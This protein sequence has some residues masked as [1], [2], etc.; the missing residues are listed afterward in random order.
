MDDEP[1]SDEA[2]PDWSPEDQWALAGNVRLRWERYS[3]DLP[4]DGGDRQPLGNLL[5]INGLGSP[6]V[7]WPVGFVAELNARGFDVVRFDNRDAG[8]SSATGGGYTLS[9]MASDAITVMDAVGWSSAHV[10]GMSMGGMIVQQ[11][12]IDHSD[13]LLSATSLMSHTGNWDYGRASDEARE[14]LMLPAPEGREAWIAQAVDTG[15]VWASPH[16]WTA[17]SSAARAA[18]LFDYGVQPRRVVNQWQA[19]VDSGDREEHLARCETPM[20][21]MHGTADTLITPEGGERTAK[22]AGNA[23]Y[24]A[25]DGM[26]HD[27]PPAYWESI[28]GH[29]TQFVQ[30]LVQ[31]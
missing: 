30:E 26:G 15:K 19:I 29:V 10:L 12:A 23:R 8:R 4:D 24:V 28:A 6:M 22:V 17:E 11:M 25:L 21:V 31:E 14:A 5:L 9:T 16:Q 13:R 7:A 1:R 3:P 2:L 18:V 20:L 27:L